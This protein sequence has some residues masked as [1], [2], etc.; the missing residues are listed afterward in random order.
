MNEPILGQADFSLRPGVRRGDSAYFLDL[1]RHRFAFD[2]FGGKYIVLLVMGSTGYSARETALRRL[3]GSRHLVEAGR[4]AFFAA[5]NERAGAPEV[6]LEKRFPSIQFLWEAEGLARALDAR[7][8]GC[9]VVLNPM[10]RVVDVV[11]LS[12][13]DRIIGLLETL[14]T[15]AGDTFRS[16]PP[17]PILSLQD[18]FEPDLCRCLVETFDRD[19]GRETGFIDTIEGR[20]VEMFDGEWKRRRDFMLSDSYLVAAVRAR[21]GRRVCP[22]IKKT[23]QFVVSRIER[24]LIARYDAESGGHFGPHRDDVS[25]L[26]AHRRFAVSINLNEDFDGGDIS[27]PEFSPQGFKP[28]PG[29][30]IVFSASILHRVSRVTRGQRYVFLTF[31]FDEE[32]ERLRLAN[33]KAVNAQGSAQSSAKADA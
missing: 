26:V 30:A 16:Y 5:G 33:L 29:A 4:I 9:W 8:G 6:E 32:A 7:E 28:A 15:A 19:G 23:F 1:G 22:E 25:A 10:L 12:A 11:P 3:N 31:L 21:I 14:P 13:G 27:F 17:V 2:T 20:S 18:V 24:D